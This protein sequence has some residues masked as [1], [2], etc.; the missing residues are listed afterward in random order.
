MNLENKAA[1]ITGASRGL[2]RALA[3][4]LAKRGAKVVLV[5]RGKAEV[6]DAAATIRA[7]GGIAHAIA[8]DIADASTA[9][10]LAGEAAALV[11]PI[12]ILVHNASELGAVPLEL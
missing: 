12:D 2:G 8:A 1:I 10:R 9:T 5:A 7:S 11:G 6:E 4:E 3:A